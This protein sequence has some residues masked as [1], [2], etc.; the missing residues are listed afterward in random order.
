MYV[1]EV[2]NKTDVVGNRI[3]CSTLEM[4][5][6]QRRLRKQLR[7]RRESVTYTPAAEPAVDKVMNEV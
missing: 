2:R 4:L 7:S 3:S 5:F 1:S 6:A